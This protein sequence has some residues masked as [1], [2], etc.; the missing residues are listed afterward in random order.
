MSERLFE[1]SQES[2]ISAE[3]AELLEHFLPE[4]VKLIAQIFDSPS[5]YW[6]AMADYRARGINAGQYDRRVDIFAELR[7]SRE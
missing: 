2:Q 1:L 5:D 6:E 3:W 7:D 4:D